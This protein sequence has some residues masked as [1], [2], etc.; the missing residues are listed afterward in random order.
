MDQLQEA[1]VMA[2]LLRRRDQFKPLGPNP[3][4]GGHGDRRMEAP[5]H[6]GGFNHTGRKPFLKPAPVAAGHTPANGLLSVPDRR[7]AS[8]IPI[9]PAPAEPRC[10]V[11]Q[12]LTPRALVLRPTATVQVISHQPGAPARRLT[13][14]APGVL[15]RVSALRQFTPGPVVLHPVG[16]KPASRPDRPQQFRP[17]AFPRPSG[18]SQ[19][20]IS[21]V[22]F[23]PPES[24]V[25]YPDREGETE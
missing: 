10:L 25:G 12:N 24:P 8:I 16:S 15:R 5:V 19:P 2:S 14:A 21:A 23:L 11:P 4:A 9:A 18:A 17:L 13:A 7:L 20:R 1:N 3:V 22:R 6:E